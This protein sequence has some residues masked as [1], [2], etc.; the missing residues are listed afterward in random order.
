MRDLQRQMAGFFWLHGVRVCGTPPRA[1]HNV[2]AA[3]RKRP[4][5]GT[6]RGECEIHEKRQSYKPA[7]GVSTPALVNTFKESRLQE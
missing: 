4:C 6:E 1:F 5:A 2:V 7:Y 3:A